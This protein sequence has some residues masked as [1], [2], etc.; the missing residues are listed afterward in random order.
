MSVESNTSNL[1][2][3]ARSAQLADNSEEALGYFNRVL[4]ADPSISEAWIGKGKAAGWLSSL[5]NI[6]TNETLV[7]FN[8]AIATAPEELKQATVEAAVGET[9]RIVVALYG[10][11]RRHLNEY[12]HLSN[13]WVAYL[14]QVAQ[15]LDALDE[16]HRWS[17]ADTTTLENIVTLCKDNI[18]GVSYRDP[19]DNNTAKAWHLSA[20]YEELIKGRLNGA[21]EDLRQL[22][23][24]YAPPTIEKKQAEACF[25]ITATMGDG[26]HPKVIL[27]RRF[28]DEWLVKRKWGRVAAGYYYSFGP[29]A[30]GI[31]RASRL[32]RVLSLILIVTPATSVATVL[33][34]ANRR[35]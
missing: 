7:A 24:S 17:P 23:P 9:N 22:D 3:L 4:E 20:Q 1:L 31:I 8:H 29:C 2:G 21:V 32:L 11:A 35:R 19:F 5:A 30:A 6:R 13:I 15:L 27:M 12:V 25:V 33:L 28:R 14:N 18:E 10:I 26:E 16:V 34:S